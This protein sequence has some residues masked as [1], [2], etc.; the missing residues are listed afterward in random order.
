MSLFGFDSLGGKLS[1]MAQLPQGTI[2]DQ[3][4]EQADK[5][6]VDMKAAAPVR[7]GK[8]RESIRKEQGTDGRSVLVKAGGPLTTRPARSGKGD[9]DYALGTEFGTSKERPE[10]FFYSTYRADK[11]AIIKAIGFRF[12]TR[13]Q[14]FKV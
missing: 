13:L 3:L 8:L 4:N 12:Y 1:E 10:P 7:T 2:A 11:P 9:Y 14:K 6:V 5:L